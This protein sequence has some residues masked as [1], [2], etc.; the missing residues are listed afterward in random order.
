MSHR[1]NTYVCLLR[2]Q[3]FFTSTP[4]VLVTNTISG[5]ATVILTPCISVLGVVMKGMCSDPIEAGNLCNWYNYGYK[6]ADCGAVGGGFVINHFMTIPDEATKI[7]E[8]REKLFGSLPGVG[9]HIA[10]SFT[11][12]NCGTQQKA[13][14][15]DAMGM[16][17]VGVGAAFAIGIISMFE[18]RRRTIRIAADLD[19]SNSNNDGQN[20]VQLNDNSGIVIV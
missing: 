16:A 18:R 20:L 4:T 5:N 15:E 17:Y 3:F 2:F 1:R 8:L 19:G 9:V 14:D 11:N 6:G 13:V 10:V 12:E 7:D